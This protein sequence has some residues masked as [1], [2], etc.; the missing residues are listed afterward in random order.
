MT[1]PSRLLVLVFLV[2]LG[3]G[4]D[5]KGGPTSGGVPPLPASNVGK[6]GGAAGSYLPPPS[7]P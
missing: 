7:P 2:A 3:V 4:C 1:F 5:S 6:S